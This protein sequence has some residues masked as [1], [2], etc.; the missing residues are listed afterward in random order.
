MKNLFVYAALATAAAFER[1]LNIDLFHPTNFM[2]VD[3]A[4]QMISMFSHPKVEANQ[5]GLV[6]WEECADDHNLFKFSQTMTSYSP[7]PIK[8][9]SQ[10]TLNLGGTTKQP[11]FV[12]FLHINVKWNGTQLYDQDVKVNQKF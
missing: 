6:K 11:L 9:G 8:M 5:T 10:L 4:K 1:P 12:D 7:D 3:V 2:S